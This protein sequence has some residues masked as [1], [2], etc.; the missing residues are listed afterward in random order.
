MAATD[1]PETDAE[2]AFEFLGRVDALRCHTSEVVRRVVRDARREQQRWKLEELA[3]IRVLDERDHLEKVA[4]T[5]VSAR[6]AQ[7]NAEVA[8]ALE[9]LPEIAKA[10]WAGEVSADQLRPLAQLATPESDAEWARRAPNLAPVD[11][12]RMVMQGRQVSA[13]EATRRREMRG[14]FAWRESEHGMTAGRWRLPDVDGV[15]VEKVLDEMAERMRPPKGKQWDS[16]A[17]RKAD[18]LVELCKHYAGATATKRQ[19]ELVVIHK[20]VGET[21]GD[22]DGIPIAE[23]TLEDLLPAARVIEHDDGA[24]PVDHGNTHD[25]PVALRREIEHRD[26]HCRYPGCE[27]TRGLQLHHLEPVAWGGHTTRKL[28][29]LLCGVDHPK[30][31]PHGIERLVGDPDLPDGLRLI[32]VTKHARAGPSP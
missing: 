21:G 19:R 16:L 15:L 9:T 24:A 27:R 12:Q 23:D 28:L 7:A 14:L 29:V 1:P 8:R 11:L 30:M 2:E 22:V 25:V 18:A 32:T 20:N 31:E 5:G 13:A 17:H 10:A 26:R 4:E 3:G 6:T